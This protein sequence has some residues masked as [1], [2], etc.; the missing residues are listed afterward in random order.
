[1]FVA[2]GGRELLPNGLDEM[3][4]RLRRRAGVEHFTGVRV[5]AHTFRHTFAVR[6]IEAGVDIYVL[7]R[8]LG[9][10]AVSTTEGYLKSVSSRAARRAAVSVL[11]RP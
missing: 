5:S 9:H 8:L 1:V 4:I 2:K 3:L 7:A 11:D 6:S 10:S